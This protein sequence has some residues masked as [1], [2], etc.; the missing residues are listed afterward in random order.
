[1][2]RGYQIYKSKFEAFNTTKKLLRLWKQS[3]PNTPLTIDAYYQQDAQAAY[4]FNDALAQAINS[5]EMFYLK[6]GKKNIFLSESVCEMLLRAKFT[7]NENATV[8]PLE[9]FEQFAIAI[10]KNLT[11]KLENGDEIPLRPCLVTVMSPKQMQSTIHQDFAKSTAIP[12]NNDHPDSDEILIGVSYNHDDTA[13]HSCVPVSATIR[14]LTQGV[15]DLEH[16]SV[17]LNQKLNAQ[18]RTEAGILFRLVTAF[19]IYTSATDGKHIHRG[20]PE[21]IDLKLP[22]G[23]NRTN[24]SA[25]FVDL[26]QKK[27]TSSPTKGENVGYKMTPHTR[28]AHMRNLQDERYYRGDNAKYPKGSRWVMVEQYDVGDIEAHHMADE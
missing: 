17:F 24:W 21:N 22:K 20:Y 11:H 19:L 6:N 1:M 23:T 14:N 2:S 27:K 5:E 18:E 7:L 9:G 15:D 8:S 4:Q 16:E 12:I 13:Y 3:K 26:P 28:P 10:P 25:S